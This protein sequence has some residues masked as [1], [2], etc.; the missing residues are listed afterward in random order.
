MNR[1]ASSWLLCAVLLLAVTAVTAQI[2]GRGGRWAA[3]LRDGLPEQRTGFLFCRLLYTSVRSEAGGSGW[4][5]DYPAADHNLMT[6]LPQ[7]THTPVTKWSD[8][9]PGYATIRPMDPDVFQCPFLFASD[10]GTSEF[11]DQEVARLREYLMKGG[12][13]WVDDFWG[14]YAWSN[15]ERQME[16]ILP[17]LVITDLKL[18]HPLF[19]VFYKVPAVPQI[20]SIS[21]W[22]RSG[23]GVSERGYDSATPHLRGIYD[24]AGR[25]IVLMSH[26]T[27]IADGWERETEDEDFF[28]LFSGRGY[29]VGV[30]VAIWAMSH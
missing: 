16:R 9:M 4:S 7:L 13:L 24:P 29:A 15:W 21:F 10:V 8:G 22:R 14:E 11:D 27:D 2:R 18:D 26:N 20:P 17:G 1:R 23:G 3:P 28:Y 30:N 25:L 19:S 6:R 12:F 5:T